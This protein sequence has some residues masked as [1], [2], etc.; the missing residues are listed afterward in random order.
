MRPLADAAC[1]LPWLA[2]SASSLVALTREPSGGLWP[3]LRGDPGLVLLVVRQT[4]HCG[5]ASSLSF[6]SSLL[7]DPGILELALQCLSQ[8]EPAFVD[9]QQPRLLPIYRA[10]LACAQTA[11]AIAQKTDRCDPDHA[12]VGG[13]LAPLGW[14]ALAANDKGNTLPSQS[15][16]PSAAIARRLAASWQLPQWLGAVVG[17]LALPL[18]TARSLGADGDHFLAVQLAG[19][20]VAEAGFGSWLAIGTPR[21]ELVEALDLPPETVQEF[22]SALKQSANALVPPAGWQAPANIALLPDL[23]RL[24]IKNR[25]MVQFAECQRLHAEVDALHGVVERQR[26]SEGQRLQE[27]KLRSLAELAAGAGHEINNPLAVI[28]GQAQYLLAGEQEPARR[29]SLQTIV[30]QTQRIHQTLTGLMQ[31]ARPPAPRKERVDLGGL[32]SD[33]VGNLRGLA[34]ERQVQLSFEEPP[35]APTLLI[36]P[37]Q[38]RTAIAALVR[39]AVE[40]APASGWATLRVQRD[41]HDGLT[42]IVEDSG[43]GPTSADREHLFDPFY[44]GRKAGRG[45]GLG[46]PAAW[47]LV[48]QHGGD[49]SFDASGNGPTR[50]LLTLPLDTIVEPLAI[51]PERNIVFPVAQSA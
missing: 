3:A 34:D 27:M 38:M 7:H 11:E 21:A 29:K 8:P 44:S 45:R 42:I 37:G 40:A 14:L 17:H 9:W 43:P 26:N 30:G 46:L 31:F 5:I 4:P 24:A 32:L 36:D 18:E 39:N 50:F 51:A 25:R 6:Y 35:G 33:I 19:L 47:Q 22:V 12:W 23:L 2:P 20:L 16:M 1:E 49:V 15:T 10:A 13:L 28:S 41:V 48:R